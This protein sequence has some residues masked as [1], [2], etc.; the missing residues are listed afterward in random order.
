MIKVSVI[1]PVYK[2]ERFLPSALDSVLAQ[3]LN[4]L[5]LICI[6]D[7]SPDRCPQILDEYAR[8]DPRVR[9]LHLPQNRRQG[10]GRNRG[11]DVARG[12]YV[13]FLDSDDMV[14]PQAMEELYAFAERET[15]DGVFFDSQV[16]FDNETLAKKHAYYQA[17]RTGT[18][19]DRVYAGRELFDAFIRQ[20]EWT[21]YVQRQFWRRELIE[22]HHIRFPEATEHED[23]WFPF[24]AILLAQ[25]VRYHPGRYF[26]RRYRE[27]SAMTRPPAPRD[28]HGYFRTY[29]LM[30]DFVA[31][32]GLQSHSTDVNIGR[33]YEKLTRFYPL[34]AAQEDPESWFASAEEKRHYRFFAYSQR[35]DAHAQD[36]C[37]EVLRRLPAQSRVWIYGAGVLGKIAYRALLS[38]GMLVEGFLVTCRSGNPAVLFGR[39]VCLADE[40]APR[41][42]ETVVIAVSRGYQAE[43]EALLAQKGWSY[44][45]IS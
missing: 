27:D 30:T 9:V 16:I 21:C 11:L 28:F 36:L 40:V 23:E 35:A 32:N 3:T 45:I 14:E 26:I 19:D 44:L 31:E 22:T 8:R 7:A 24:Q 39:P 4:E 6:D 18:Y 29:C 1:M 2:V 13:Y 12:K 41:E 42:G 38:A 17:A 43:V 33:I 37:R 34:F 10:Y 15:L 25:R 5:E 20:R